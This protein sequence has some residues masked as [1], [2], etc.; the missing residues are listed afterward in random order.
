MTAAERDQGVT[1]RQQVE[2]L[3]E[4]YRGVW[5]EW[6]RLAGLLAAETDPIRAAEVAHE[7]AA[8]TPHAVNA[9]LR[10]LPLLR[11]EARWREL[12]PVRFRFLVDV[13]AIHAVDR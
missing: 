5:D 8:K 11:M 6:L 1:A 4:E 7:V 13:A 10:A 12:D 9:R 3:L 2:A